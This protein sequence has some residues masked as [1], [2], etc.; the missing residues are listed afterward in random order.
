MAS[1]IVEA[2][3][4]LQTVFEARASY[5]TMLIITRVC[6][7]LVKLLNQGVD[8]GAPTQVSAEQSLNAARSASLCAD[9]L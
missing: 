5:A 1:S 4:Q 9:E 6:Q 8:D 7:E 2:A 3:V